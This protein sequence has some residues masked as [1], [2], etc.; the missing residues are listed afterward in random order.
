MSMALAEIRTFVRSVP[1]IDSEDL[2]D[3][4]LD[5]FIQE[6]FDRIASSERT[7]DFYQVQYP[8][9]VINGTQT[10]ALASIG[11][12]PIADVSAIQATNWLL[13]PAPH[14]L[15]LQRYMSSSAI[16][17]GE[18]RTW[19]QWGANLYLWPTPNTSPTLQVYGY[20]EP[21][22]WIADGAGAVPDLPTD[23]HGLVALWALARAYEQQDDI[24]LGERK[25][26]LFDTQF[27]NLREKFIG[28][29]PAG[30]LVLNGG[31]GQVEAYSLP[32][33]PRFAWEW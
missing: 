29:G 7:W 28:G 19:S 22:D 27:A 17:S 11:A 20:R 1:D 3:T 6:G 32:F 21:Q 18:P 26:A 4:T 30:P 10:Y 16:T 24:E 25:Q 12:E 31:K 33:G 14:Q 9:S 2:D 23:F 13:K 8:L 5:V 15:A